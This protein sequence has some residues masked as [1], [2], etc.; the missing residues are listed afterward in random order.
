MPGA[1]RGRCPPTWRGR[2]GACGRPSWPGARARGRAAAADRDRAML[3]RLDEAR[4]QSSVEMRDAD[5]DQEPGEAYDK[6]FAWYGID[7]RN[8]ARA[9]PRIRASRIRDDLL[10]ALDDWIA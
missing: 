6:A 3:R 5:L 8:P 7:V 10:A 1:W 4:W 9:G 2:S